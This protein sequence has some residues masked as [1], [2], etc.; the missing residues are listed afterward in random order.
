[1]KQSHSGDLLSQYSQGQRNFRG[2]SLQGLELP[3][4]SLNHSDFA[5]CNLS[6]VN[7]SGAD[8]IK[9]NFSK[10]NLR[11]AKLIGADLSGANLVDA[12]LRGALLSG[13]ILVGAYLSRANLEQAVLSGAVLNGAV[14]RDSH[15]RDANLVGADLSGADLLGADARESDLAEAQLEGAVL[16]DGSVRYT[17]DTQ[18]ELAE[19]LSAQNTVVETHNAPDN[20]TIICHF[21][22]APL[23]EMTALGNE[24]L[25]IDPGAKDACHLVSQTDELI[26]TRTLVSGLPTVTLYSHTSMTTSVDQLLG[27]LGFLPTREVLEPMAWVEYRHGE[28]LPGYEHTFGEARRLWKSWWMGQQAEDRQGCSAILV[29][30]DEQWL[31]LVEINFAGF[32]EGLITITLTT[33]AAWVLSPNEKINWLTPDIPASLASEAGHQDAAAEPVISW[34]Q[35]R[36]ILVYQ[37]GQLRI[38]TSLGELIVQGESLACALNDVALPLT[39]L[40][41][42][43]R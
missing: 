39:E 8:L 22:Q 18:G 2:M 38:Q 15:L 42:D 20:E 23:A 33:G 6:G 10:A 16:P 26:A 25:H 29:W 19:E 30:R 35:I 27:E 4:A 28:R 9:V 17:P 36:Q 31:P 43:Q 1:M 14:L 12:D 41:Q 24:Y 5:N 11:N 7:W 40:F 32:P 34:E 3:L 21:L 13:A 37:P